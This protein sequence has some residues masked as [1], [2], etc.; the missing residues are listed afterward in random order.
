MSKYVDITPDG[1]MY[2]VKNGETTSLDW[3]INTDG[4]PVIYVSAY[5]IQTQG[6]ATVKE[7]YDAYHAQW[8]DKGTEWGST[9]ITVEPDTS[10]YDNNKDATEYNISTAAELFGLAKIVNSGEYA[11]DFKNDLSTFYFKGKTI[12]L[13]ADIDLH[14]QPWTPIGQTGESQF[15]GTFDGN[16]KTIKNLSITEDATI[17]NSNEYY[18]VGLFG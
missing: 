7:A 4:N 2:L 18:A 5:A 9:T 8:G 17:V 12:K 11:D 6:F 1:D 16:G 10:W 13:T 3:N 15:V 14:D